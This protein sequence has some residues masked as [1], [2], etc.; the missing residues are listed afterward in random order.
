MSRNIANEKIRTP[1]MAKIRMA[2]TEVI[3]K[4]GDYSYRGYLVVEFE[5]LSGAVRCV[6]EDENGRLFIHNPGQVERLA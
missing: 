6:V 3:V 4:A 2:P 1:K 5:K